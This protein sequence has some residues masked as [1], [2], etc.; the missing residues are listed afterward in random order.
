[1]RRRR[2]FTIGSALL[3]GLAVFG[4]ACFGPTRAVAED[5]TAEDSTA[6]DSTMEAFEERTFSFTSADGKVRD[7]R[8]RLLRPQAVEPG[9][10]YP[11]IL[12]LHG[13]GERGD[14]NRKQLLYLPESMA[15]AER[16]AKYPC[17]LIAPQCPAEERWADVDWSAAEA[18]PLSDA[19][20]PPLR[21]ALGMLQEVMRDEAVD[22]NRVYLTGL[23]MG[24]YG[25]WDLAVR[26][27]ELFAAVAPICG[28]GDESQAARLV[29][30]PVWAFHGDE[31]AAV[32]VAR[33]RNM[34][35]AIKAAGGTPKYT[36]Y[37]GFGHHSWVPAYADD[38]GLLDW[39]FAQRRES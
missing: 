25:S 29:G 35:T 6:E 15:T 9:R 7:F 23:S 22:A 20:A 12:F 17:F 28:G 10:K 3:G 38:S 1:M 32:P 37:P 36:E 18:E 26:H 19:P 24:G 34:I 14:D 5:P 13:A 31:D 21:A 27:P 2:Q 8:Y 30:I 39:M 4:A 33:S 16:R 11:V